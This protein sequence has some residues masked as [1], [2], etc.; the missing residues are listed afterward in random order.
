MANI[1]N[2]SRE[3]LG[4]VSDGVRT[5][6]LRSHSPALYQLSYAH[7]CLPLVRDLDSF[8]SNSRHNF[9]LKNSQANGIRI[10]SSL[11]FVL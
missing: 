8:G 9:N 2:P 10:S 1:F 11:I 3:V 5:R 7:H 6:D 4:G